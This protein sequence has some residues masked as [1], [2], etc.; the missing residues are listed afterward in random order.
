[1]KEKVLYHDSLIKIRDSSIILKHYYL[2][3]ISKVISF[4][5]IETIETQ[6][7]PSIETK[8]LFPI[9]WRLYGLGIIGGFITWLPLDLRRPT[10]DKIFLITYKHQRIKSGFTVENSERVEG[11]FREKE[12]LLKIFS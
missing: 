5:N 9:G 4:N 8:V 12:W 3:F 6:E 7:L 11:I 2:P 1:M 10:R